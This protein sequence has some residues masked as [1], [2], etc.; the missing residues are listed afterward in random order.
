MRLSSAQ[1]AAVH[2]SPPP[3][4]PPSPRRPRSSFPSNPFSKHTP[5]PR[6][7]PE[8]ASPPHAGPGPSGLC[9]PPP[10]LG[11]D[12][13]GH[14][15]P[16]HGK[17]QP[18]RRGDAEAQG[19]SPQ[20]TGNAAAILLCCAGCPEVPPAWAGL[21]LTTPPTRTGGRG[22]GASRHPFRLYANWTLGARLPGVN[23]AGCGQ[24]SGRRVCEERFPT[25]AMVNAYV[26]LPNAT[27]GGTS[28]EV[29]TA[30]GPGMMEGR[31]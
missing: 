26:P 30:F 13:E 12:D 15:P 3:T 20:A 18:N 2:A 24:P 14:S 17:E 4:S 19:C 8:P 28:M 5:P 29:F 6:M 21:V 10:R 25:E 27:A 7:R 22:R 11:P 31:P 16:Q 23:L 1:S 9:R